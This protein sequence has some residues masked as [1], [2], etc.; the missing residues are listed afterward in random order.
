[1]QLLQI[2]NYNIDKRT[3]KYEKRSQTYTRRS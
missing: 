3:D 2:S 1:M